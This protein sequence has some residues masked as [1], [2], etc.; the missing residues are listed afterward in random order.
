M[1]LAFISTGISYYLYTYLTAGR[2]TN[3]SALMFTT[4]TL[5]FFMGLISEQIT[6]L[7]YKTDTISTPLQA[8]P[9]NPIKTTNQT[10]TESE[11]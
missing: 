5:M 7:L 11:G 6:A 8:T 9:Q 3:M 1:A 10:V 2:F 4:G